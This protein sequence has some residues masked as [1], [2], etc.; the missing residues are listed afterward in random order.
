MYTTDSHLHE[1]TPQCGLNY[2]DI[3]DDQVRPTLMIRL[4]LGTYLH[5]YMVQNSNQI[6]ACAA[7]CYKPS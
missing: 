3:F 5:V 6:Y 4:G 7:I 1:S 2:I